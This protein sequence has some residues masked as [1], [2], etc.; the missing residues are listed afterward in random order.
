LHHNARLRN[1]KRNSTN[2]VLSPHLIIPYHVGYFF[3]LYM[4]IRR[5]AVISS[6]PQA[7]DAAGEV[8]S[9]GVA[10]GNLEH[11]QSQLTSSASSRQ[12]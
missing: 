12:P 8:G 11:H 10:S 1:I 5:L 3:F 2:A 7:Q 9:K 6:T 4:D